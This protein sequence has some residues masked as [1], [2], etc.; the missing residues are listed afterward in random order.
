MR[1]VHLV[2]TEL[3][4]FLE[5]EHIDYALLGDA[6]TPSSAAAHRI[7]LVITPE[8]LEH[9]PLTLHEFCQQSDSKLV[10]CSRE[11]RL[12]WRCIVSWLNRDERPE[13][14]SIEVFAG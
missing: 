6:C 8:V 2:A 12:G 11:G 3:C 1:S 4:R 7:E 5:A 13:F 9:V 14:V 10:T